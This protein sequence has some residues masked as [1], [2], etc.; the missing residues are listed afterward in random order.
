[1]ADDPLVQVT[2]RYTSKP[3]EE[4]ND[5]QLMPVSQL[6]AGDGR[7]VYSL[8]SVLERQHSRGRVTL[9]SADAREAPRIENN[10][11][12]RPED[13]RRLADGVRF[14]AR[15]GAHEGFA[16]VDAGLL[17]PP[18]AVLEDDEALLS[19]CAHVAASGFHPSC[20]ARMGAAD[21]RDAVVDQHL[22]VHGV[23]RLYVAD[24]SIMPACPRANIHLTSI[25]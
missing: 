22:R 21:D 24:A 8:A 13:T 17:S 10:F 3:G 14:A 5:M 12:D 15:V 18:Q 4:R 9:T 20:T 7:M 2:Y 25:M 23:E 6:P 1:H 19:W 11:C 16:P